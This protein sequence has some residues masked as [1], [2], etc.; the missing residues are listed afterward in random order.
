ME[1]LGSK[2]SRAEE[3]TLEQD[4]KYQAERLQNLRLGKEVQRLED[5]LKFLKEDLIELDL[6]AS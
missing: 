1:D 4:E 5:E 2:L 3:G 6:Q